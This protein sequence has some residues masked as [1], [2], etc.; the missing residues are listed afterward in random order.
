MGLISS[1]PLAVKVPQNHLCGALSPGIAEPSSRSSCGEKSGDGVEK[2]GNCVKKSSDGVAA[3]QPPLG[4]S[5]SWKLLGYDDMA[6]WLGRG[7]LRS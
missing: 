1:L 5:S 4:C 7:S 3:R 6:G 2:S